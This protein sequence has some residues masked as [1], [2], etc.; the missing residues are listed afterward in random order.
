[1]LPFDLMTGPIFYH[2]VR[3]GAND[4]F[5]LLIY[6]APQGNMLLKPLMQILV[7]NNNDNNNNNFIASIVHDT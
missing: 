1:M 2:R 3:D 4:S 5:F 7:I 6:K